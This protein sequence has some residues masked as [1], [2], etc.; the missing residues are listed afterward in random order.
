MNINYRPYTPQTKKLLT[1]FKVY[2]TLGVM[3]TVL[4][5][6]SAISS[7]ELLDSGIIPECHVNT[8]C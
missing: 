6:V 5:L 3:L 2:T 7:I 8:E 1:A 4:L